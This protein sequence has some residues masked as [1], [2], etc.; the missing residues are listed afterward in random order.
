LGW[1]DRAST[2]W[3]RRRGWRKANS[4]LVV[5]F[6]L[7]DGWRS[8]FFQRLLRACCLDDIPCLPSLFVP[9]ARPPPAHLEIWLP[10]FISAGPEMAS[11][12]FPRRP[13]LPSHSGAAQIRQP[14][15]CSQCRQMGGSA[16]I[17]RCGTLKKTTLR[18]P[19]AL[20]C[21]LARGAAG[22][23]QAQGLVVGEQGGQL[24]LPAACIV[25]F[26]KGIN[27]I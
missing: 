1:D 11:S 8:C 3:R 14:D 25:A 24:C 12:C 4:C 7:M 16:T 15:G 22:S 23:C 27:L 10:I 21:A 6:F 18:D 2:V 20:C 17:P 9:T 13:L 26:L 19:S 5:V